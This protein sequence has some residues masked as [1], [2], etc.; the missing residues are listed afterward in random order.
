MGAGKK[1]E[2]RLLPVPRGAAEEGLSVLG[3]AISAF[4]AAGNISPIIVVHPLNAEEGEAAAREAAGR[5][6]LNMAQGRILFTPGGESRRQSVYNALKLLRSFPPDYVLIHDGA[7]PWV[8]QDLINRVSSAMFEHG[9]AI[10]VL[11]LTE[12]PKLV[13]N[14]FVHRHLKRADAAAAQT[15]QGFGFSAILAAH[16]K[17]A[18]RSFREGVE[19][20]DD[21]EIYGEFAGRVAVVDGD[22]LNRKITFPADLQDKAVEEKK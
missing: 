20:T 8:S 15:P 6:L 10:P 14:G 17:A 2:Y 4:R 12:T 5:A 9:A 13:L 3:A 22:F 21:A 11:P 19:Y 16:E 7:R 18:E 1:K